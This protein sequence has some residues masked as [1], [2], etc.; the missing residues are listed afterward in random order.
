M[1][2]LSERQEDFQT[3]V[4][5]C[6][7]SDPA[8]VSSSGNPWLLGFRRQG[9]PPIPVMVLCD[10]AL[11]SNPQ[12]TSP[13]LLSSSGI[14]LLHAVSGIHIRPP[15]HLVV[16]QTLFVA[17]NRSVYFFPPRLHR[18]PN[19]HRPPLRGPFQNACPIQLQYNLFN[20]TAE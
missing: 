2:S 13:L 11:L 7:A 15:P 9:N 16:P 5:L 4:L 20:T 14:F 1:G 19:P 12:Q 17:K 3:D 18:P 10:C 8:D 6:H